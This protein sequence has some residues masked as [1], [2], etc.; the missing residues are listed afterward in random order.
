MSKSILIIGAEYITYNILQ[1]LCLTDHTIYIYDYRILTKR[2]IHRL[3]WWIT[4]ENEE[5]KTAGE[6]CVNYFQKCQNI[7]NK[8]LH[9]IELPDIVVFTTSHVFKSGDFTKFI[10][11][12]ITADKK[13]IM[14]MNHHLYAYYNNKPS[15][16]ID[17]TN[18]HIYSLNEY[19]RINDQI[20]NTDLS[21]EYLKYIYSCVKSTDPD[22]IPDRFSHSNMNS[23]FYPLATIIAMYVVRDIIDIWIETNIIID[24][25]QLRDDEVYNM[26]SDIDDYKYSFKSDFIHLLRNKQLLINA[27]NDEDVFNLVIK[28]LHYLGYLKYSSK[29]IYIMDDIND[30]SKYSNFEKIDNITDNIVKRTDQSWCITDNSNTKV[31]WDVLHIKYL[32][33]SI[34]I[35]VYDE[36]SKITVIN[37]IPYKTE[38]YNE[39]VNYR[40]DKQLINRGFV[41]NWKLE[42]SVSISILQWII[43]TIILNTDNIK[44]RK[45]IST[46]ISNYPQYIIPNKYK[47]YYNNMLLDGKR[48]TTIPEEFNTWSRIDVNEKGDVAE[49]LGELL[50][51]MVDEYSIV[52]Y[53]VLYEYKYVLFDKVKYDATNNK[54]LHLKKRIKTFMYKYTS[55]RYDVV[56]LLEFKCKNENGDDILIPP[57]YYHCNK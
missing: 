35:N 10:E 1:Y 18:P 50:N 46:S 17:D 14:A 21:K 5:H 20:D 4:N 36:L 33:P 31:L 32:K 13:I 6:I 42:F 28:Q 24:W 15:I 30:H 38:T 29:K 56:G 54:E 12:C 53:M 34:Y 3:S 40:Q 39:S 37:S 49:T 45:F 11:R 9:R 22:N 41:I 27:N 2:D 51:H 57:V 26:K 52:P 47:E 44:F 16:N 43:Q 23:I 8:S 19:V 48:I 55:D 7:L 25:S